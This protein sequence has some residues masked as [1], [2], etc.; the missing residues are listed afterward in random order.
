MTAVPAVCFAC[1]SGALAM[2]PRTWVPKHVPLQQDGLAGAELPTQHPAADV[3][4]RPEAS[5]NCH[6]AGAQLQCGTARALHGRAE[7]LLVGSTLIGVSVPAPRERTWLSRDSIENEPTKMGS[8][9]LDTLRSVSPMLAPYWIV[10]LQICAPTRGA[11]AAARRTSISAAA[12]AAAGAAPACDG[13]AGP[14]MQPRPRAAAAPRSAAPS[15]LAGSAAGLFIGAAAT[16]SDGGLPH[17]SRHRRVP[18]GECCSRPPWR[19][20]RPRAPSAGSPSLAAAPAAPVVVISCVPGP[21]GRSGV[22][23]VARCESKVRADRAN[24]APPRRAFGPK[25]GTKRGKE[26][27]FAF[28]G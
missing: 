21:P 5:R 23:L 28:M 24:A 27:Y 6:A 26:Q 7:H 22:F 16:A 18:E 20:C 13:A 19:V 17:R 11:A 1:P 2:R 9:L 14:A 15:P 4:L 25:T 3:D 10:T 12:A 8:S